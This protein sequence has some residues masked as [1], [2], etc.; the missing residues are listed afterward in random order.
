MSEDVREAFYQFNF[1]KKNKG[2]DEGYVSSAKTTEYTGI[3]RAA[4]MLQFMFNA[5]CP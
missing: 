4:I 5:K 2:T 3:R 1:I